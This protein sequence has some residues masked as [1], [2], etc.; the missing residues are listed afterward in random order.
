M[1]KIPSRFKT[2]KRKDTKKYIVSLSPICGL[3]AY[4]CNQWDRASFANFPDELAHLREPKSKSAADM[5]IK[6]L[7]KQLSAPLPYSNKNG[8]P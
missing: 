7:K 6:Y 1:P 3:P 5:L 8:F 4:I 2:Y